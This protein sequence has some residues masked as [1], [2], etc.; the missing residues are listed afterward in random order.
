MFVEQ[1][2]TGRVG[3]ERIEQIFVVCPKC[4]E[5]VSVSFEGFVGSLPQVQQFWRKHGRMRT[6][7]LRE[8]EAEGRPALVARYESVTT[9]D[10]LTLVVARNSFSLLQVQGSGAG[11]ADL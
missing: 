11:K 3:K 5:V 9:A 8:I 4:D 7:P 1:V 2:H 6:L 10:Q